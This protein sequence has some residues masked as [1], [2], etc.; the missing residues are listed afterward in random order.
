[1]AKRKRYL[2][3]SDI[4]ELRNQSERELREIRT[5]FSDPEL[6]N[7]DL[8]GREYKSHNVRLCIVFFEN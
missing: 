8:Y 3:E 1:M 6:S 4:R 7:T 5:V 2:T